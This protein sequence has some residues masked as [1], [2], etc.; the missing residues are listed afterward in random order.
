M[1]LQIHALEYFLQ[2][3]APTGLDVHTETDLSPLPPCTRLRK[4]KCKGRTKKGPRGRVT[5]NMVYPGLRV[6]FRTWNFQC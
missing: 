1:R 6:F 3:T 2:L 5:N 4:G